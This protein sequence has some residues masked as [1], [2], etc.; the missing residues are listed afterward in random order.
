MERTRVFSVL[1]ADEVP[2][3]ADMEVM[4]EM[5]VCLSQLLIDIPQIKQLD[6]NS[7]AISKGRP[8]AVDARIAVE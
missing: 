1:K 5:R 7:V 6:I 2:G 8:Y 3:K 4:E